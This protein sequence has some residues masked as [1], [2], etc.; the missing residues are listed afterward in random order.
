MSGD[1]LPDPSVLLGPD[2]NG[3]RAR[4]TTEEFLD[5]HRRLAYTMVFNRFKE[6]V[7]KDGSMD[8]KH[9]MFEA[10]HLSAWYAKRDYPADSKGRPLGQ[11][12]LSEL[13]GVNNQRV[14]EALHE[15]REEHYIKFDSP[16]GPFFLIDDPEDFRNRKMRPN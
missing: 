7:M 1:T 16:R 5:R 3:E 11:K 14:S 4:S 6:S 13:V 12:E 8:M 2:E 15:L 10:M 9:R